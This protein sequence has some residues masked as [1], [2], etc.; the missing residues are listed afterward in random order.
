MSTYF[1][2]TNLH[3]LGNIAAVKQQLD[4]WEQRG[5]IDSWH[6]D[7]TNPDAPLEIVTQQLTPELVKHRIRA[8]GVDAEF[9]APPDSGHRDRGHAPGRP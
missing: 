5:E 8:L 9:S 1:F 6:I 2:R 7:V 4:Q 3:G